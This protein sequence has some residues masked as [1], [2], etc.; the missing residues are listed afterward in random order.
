MSLKHAR[1]PFRHLGIGFILGETRRF[2][3][4]CLLCYGGVQGKLKFFDTRL[5]VFVSLKT[6]PCFWRVDGVK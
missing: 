4:H 3:R 2:A 1:L 5:G 6:F